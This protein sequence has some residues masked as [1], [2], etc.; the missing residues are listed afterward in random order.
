MRILED[1]SDLVFGICDFWTPGDCMLGCPIK[2]H[3]GIRV[4]FIGRECTHSDNHFAFFIP[5][6]HCDVAAGEKECSRFPSDELGEALSTSDADT[7]DC[8]N[9]A[10]IASS[11]GYIFAQFTHD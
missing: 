5:H 6:E 1:L 10:W 9:S 11:Y 2:N 3:S 4:A 8:G 7:V